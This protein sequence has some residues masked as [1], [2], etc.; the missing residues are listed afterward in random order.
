MARLKVKIIKSIL[1]N[2]KKKETFIR[3]KNMKMKI[4]IHLIS[5]SFISF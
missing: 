3:N 2:N 4:I 5:F 1:S